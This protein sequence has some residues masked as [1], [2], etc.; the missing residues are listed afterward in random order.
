MKV[1]FVCSGNK[2]GEIGTVVQNQAQSIEQKGIQVYFFPI[3]GGGLNS[4]LKHIQ[5][6][7]DFIRAN[8][9]DLTHAHYSFSGIVAALAGCKPLVVS[10]MG[11]DS[12]S[13]YFLKTFTRVSYFFLWNTVI[14]KSDLMRSQTGIKKAI[15]LPNGVNLSKIDSIE[16]GS[17][18]INKETI[19]FPA[20]PYRKSKNFS[21]AEKAVA[22]VDEDIELKVVFSKSHKD[23]IKEMKSAG[24]VL[25]SSRWEGSPNI[26]KEAMACERPIVSTRV[27]DVEWL[28]GNE[29]GHY[30]ASHNAIDLSNK[31]ALAYNFTRENENTNGRKR[32]IKLGLD[33]ETIAD[34]IIGIYSN[35]KE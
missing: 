26:I 22:L 31:I 4:Y 9:F 35:L 29:P 14:V 16:I 8:R 18:G 34:R 3:I 1:L 6:L 10:L 28:F 27:G 21:L 11:S 19:L 33:S 15:V 32:L 17:D 24:I 2:D 25:L 5:K 12:I 7:K 13:N 30:L 23:V 20:D